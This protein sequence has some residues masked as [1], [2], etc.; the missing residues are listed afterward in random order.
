MGCHLQTSVSIVVCPEVSVQFVLLMGVRCH[1]AS[2]S[3]VDDIG[4]KRDCVYKAFH[5]TCLGHGFPL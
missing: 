5:S 1:R 4:S 2:F 3:T